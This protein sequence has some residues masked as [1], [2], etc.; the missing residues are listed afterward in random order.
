MFWPKDPK[1]PYRSHVLEIVSK[2]SYD[3][4][5]TVIRD[6]FYVEPND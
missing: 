1:F 4:N 6:V 3:E 5:V 2:F